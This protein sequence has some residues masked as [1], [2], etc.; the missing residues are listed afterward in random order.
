MVPVM[1]KRLI[2]LRKR[3]EKSQSQFAQTLGMAQ[4][5]YSPLENDPNR[6]V[7]DAYIKLICKVHNVNEKWLRDGEGDMFNDKPDREI[8]ELL[9]IYDNLSPSLK[10][11][12]LRHAQELK[13]L[14]NELNV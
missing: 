13:D 3:L 5:T 4:S 1:K 7:R 2:E 9:N 11:Y 8:E 6:N 12:L 10:K 14:Q